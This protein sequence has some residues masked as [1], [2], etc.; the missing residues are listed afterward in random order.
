MR[1]HA[2]STPALTSHI[3]DT[4]EPPWGDGRIFEAALVP[5][6]M[7]IVPMAEFRVKGVKDRETKSTV[8]SKSQ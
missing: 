2:G 7:G 4:L 8:K 1:T 3:P 6:G 5:V